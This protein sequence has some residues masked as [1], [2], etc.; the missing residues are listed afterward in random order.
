MV[1]IKQFKIVK[2]MDSVQEFLSKTQFFP[3]AEIC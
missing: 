1:S 3:E 2:A